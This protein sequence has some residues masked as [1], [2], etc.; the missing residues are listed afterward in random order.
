MKMKFLKPTTF[1]CLATTISSTLITPV[2]A[3]SKEVNYDINN[4]ST[5]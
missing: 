5:K 2:F 1:L 4:M 3:D